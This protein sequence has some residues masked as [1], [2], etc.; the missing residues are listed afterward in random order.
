MADRSAAMVENI[1][2]VS[3]V[4]NESDIIESFCRHALTFSDGL[5][6]C[7]DGSVDETV[8]IINKMIDEGLNI[9]L[10]SNE[11]T[12]GHC[13]EEIINNLAHFAIDNLGADLIIPL[14]ADEFL[15]TLSTFSLRSILRQCSSNGK[16]YI[17]WMNFI[18]DEGIKKNDKALPCYFNKYLSHTD[19]IKKI[20]IGKELLKKNA[21]VI[22]Q[23]SHSIRMPEKGNLL[24]MELTRLPI[25]LA[26]YPIRSVE[27]AM[28]K[29]IIGWSNFLC[30]SDKMIN[31][32]KKPAHWEQM[33]NYIKEHGSLSYN[34]L[35]KLV[36]VY[37]PLEVGVYTMD[38]DLPLVDYTFKTDIVLKYTDYEKSQRNF[39][40]IIL[41]HYEHIIDMFRIREKEKAANP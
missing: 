36:N 30:D 39:L 2:S 23:G 22:T 33:Y 5:V 20:I 21:A 41:S 13:Q 12:F 3:M 26:H 18:P 9:V 10:F 31:E 35:I 17:M 28:T 7:D 14:D 16:Y 24:I 34:N 38:K 40:S 27:Q 32:N 8:V 15:I 37:V 4:K 1:Y 29:I 11:N 19:A 25:F 6:I